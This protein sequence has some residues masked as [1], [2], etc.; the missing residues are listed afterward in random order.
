MCTFDNIYSEY[1]IS[2]NLL[3]INSQKGV[4]IIKRCYDNF[5]ENSLLKIMQN[6]NDKPLNKT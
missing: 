3:K 4:Q 5:Y 6:C 1:E 2:S